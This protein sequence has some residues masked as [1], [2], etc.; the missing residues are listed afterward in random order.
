MCINCYEKAIR[1]TCKAL[2][3]N[4]KLHCITL[5]TLKQAM[6][7]AIA[8]VQLFLPISVMGQLKH[9]ATKPPQR[10]AMHEQTRNQLLSID[11]LARNTNIV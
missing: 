3:L 11:H 2:I 9:G 7:L 4:G 8:A 5:T 1:C 6:D 10:L